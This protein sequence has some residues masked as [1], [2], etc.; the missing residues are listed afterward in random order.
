MNSNGKKFKIQPIKQIREF[1]QRVNYVCFSPDCSS[2]ETNNVDNFILQLDVKPGEQKAKLFIRYAFHL[3]LLNQ[4]LQSRMAMYQKGQQMFKLDGPNRIANSIYFSPDGTILAS[5][6]KD[7]S[8]QLLDV[9]TREVY[10]VDKTIISI[11]LKLLFSIDCLLITPHLIVEIT[12]SV[13]VP[14]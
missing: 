8:K 4:H 5:S 12:L 2:I 3:M 14:S 9:K 10:R 13:Y 11:Q 7:K 1:Y 6:S